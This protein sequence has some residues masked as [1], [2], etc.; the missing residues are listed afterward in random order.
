MLG[1]GPFSTT[2]VR[3]DE[4]VDL[5][6]VTSLTTSFFELA[7][8]GTETKRGV[9]VDT[10]A[11]SLHSALQARRQRGKTPVSTKYILH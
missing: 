4:A 2:S 5:S 1:T 9:T 7:D 8:Y 11:A 6:F 3:H 10:N